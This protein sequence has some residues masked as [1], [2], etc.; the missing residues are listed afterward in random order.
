MQYAGGSQLRQSPP[1]R[2]LMA[3]FPPLLRDGMRFVLQAPLDIDLVGHAQ[4][5]EE[6]LSLCESLSPDVLLFNANTAAPSDVAAI[7]YLR[8]ENIRWGILVYCQ[9]DISAVASRMVDTGANGYLGPEVE[10]PELVKAIRR[11]ARGYRYYSETMI[12][13][14]SGVSPPTA[15]TRRQQEVLR[16]LVRAH[17]DRDIAAALGLSRSAIHA[18]VRSLNK[19]L[20]VRTRA[21]LAVMAVTRGFESL[22]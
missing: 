13:V 11:V 3:N 21:Q 1:I 17:S 8:G 22:D 20:G 7:R 4:G 19:K 15:L 9:N 2:L 5:V 10:R 16:L 6:A 14:I 12:K 18:H